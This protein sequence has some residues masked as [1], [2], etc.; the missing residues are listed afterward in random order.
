MNKI[1]F[2]EEWHQETASFFGLISV[3]GDFKRMCELIEKYKPILD[4]LHRQ[5]YT[6]FANEQGMQGEQRKAFFDMVGVTE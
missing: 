5:R 6:D 1:Q 4:N 2:L 3:A